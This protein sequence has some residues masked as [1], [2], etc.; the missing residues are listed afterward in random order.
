MPSSSAIARR[1]EAWSPVIIRTPIPAW[2]QR[3]TAAT[4]SGRAGSRMP[5]SASRCRSTTRGAG[6]PR[7]PPP[8]SCSRGWRAR[9]PVGPRTERFIVW[10][11]P[12]ATQPSRTWAFAGSA[13]A[14]AARWASTTS[15]AP[16]TTRSDRSGRRDP[17]ASVAMNL[18]AESKGSSARGDGGGEPRSGRPQPSGEHHQ[19]GLRR[20][21]DDLD[22]VR[23]GVLASSPAVGTT[24]SLH[25]T[26]STNA[27][28]TSPTPALS[29]RFAGRGV[30]SPPAAVAHARHDVVVARHERFVWRSS[31]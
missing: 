6:R 21:A 5:T 22:R 16:F 11:D 19:G 1:V 18:V 24:A 23:P 14:T 29:P 3:A 7:T 2:W 26:A 28:R 13:P 8:G 10:A 27:S 17:G 9:A 15:G 20:V 12:G 25:S 30:G 4:A 31:G